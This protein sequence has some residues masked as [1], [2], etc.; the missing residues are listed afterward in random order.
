MVLENEKIE[1]AEDVW[2]ESDKPKRRKRGRPS[3]AD[4]QKIK[5][6]Q[7]KA[8]A[9][10]KQELIKSATD[11]VKTGL[12]AI[13]HILFRN[14]PNDLKKEG[15]TELSDDELN[16]LSA[17]TV[18]VLD[19]YGLLDISANPELVLISTV[20]MLAVPRYNAVTRYRAKNKVK[21]IPPD[22]EKEK[23]NADK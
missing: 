8:E 5:E 7:E 17:A 6:Q 18:P 21:N 15:C 20:I 16:M 19:K 14:L 10:K 13:N 12:S 23:E 3:T 11:L 2:T 22:K 9:E 4:S 1:K